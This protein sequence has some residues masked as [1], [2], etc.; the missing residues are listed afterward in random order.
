VSGERTRIMAG[1]LM[2]NIRLHVDWASGAV[3]LVVEAA[4]R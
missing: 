4:C 2:D 1:V 3:E